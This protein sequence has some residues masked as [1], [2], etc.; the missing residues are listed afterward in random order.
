MFVNFPIKDVYTINKHACIS[1][2]QK[3]DHALA[4]GIDFHFLNDGDGN[5]GKGGINDYPIALE[6][7]KRVKAYVMENNGELHKTAIGWIIL[8][9]DSFFVHWSKQKDN[10]MWILTAI[11]VPNPNAI[12]IHQNYTYCLDIGPSKKDHTKV[13]NHYIKQIETIRSG[14]K[15]FWGR[16]KKS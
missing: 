7:E 1:L 4:L 16:K 15:R 5:H 2:I 12:P 8:W 6:L 14:Q 11:I 3:L 13:I 9:S 10:S